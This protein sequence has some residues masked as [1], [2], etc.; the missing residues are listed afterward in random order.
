M[1]HF[2]LV[3]LRQ[4]GQVPYQ[5][6]PYP[7]GTFVLA[8]HLN[9]EVVKPFEAGRTIAVLHPFLLMFEYK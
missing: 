7:R 4:L 2:L 3:Q 8:E 5:V 1:P 9:L 6:L